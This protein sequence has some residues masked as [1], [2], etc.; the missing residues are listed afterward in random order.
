MF[1]I[2]HLVKGFGT[3]VVEGAIRSVEVDGH[4]VV[5]LIT[6]MWRRITV[7]LLAHQFPQSCI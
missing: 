7:Q 6:V 1:S 4:L 2:I 5:A 3:H